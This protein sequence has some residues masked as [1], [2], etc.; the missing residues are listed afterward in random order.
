MGD[1]RNDGKADE[2]ALSEQTVTR[3]NVELSDDVSQQ[4]KNLA[5]VCGKNI[6][7]TACYITSCEKYE[8][9]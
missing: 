8:E 1:K 3:R 9:N 5:S 4:L 2:V 6:K 7:F